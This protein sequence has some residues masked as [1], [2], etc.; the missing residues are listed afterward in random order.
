MIGYIPLLNSSSVI[1]KLDGMSERAM[2]VQYNKGSET[3]TVRLRSGDYVCFPW[4]NVK[5]L[6]SCL[7]TIFDLI[8]ELVMI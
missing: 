3:Y 7:D 5:P 6:E 8:N 2:I 4:N 1:V